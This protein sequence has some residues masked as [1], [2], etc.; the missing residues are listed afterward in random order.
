MSCSLSVTKWEKLTLFPV[1]LFVDT[2]YSYNPKKY[3][4]N[5]I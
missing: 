1:S 3:R 4:L 5:H 2:H